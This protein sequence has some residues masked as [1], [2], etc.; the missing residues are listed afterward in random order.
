VQRTRRS[1]WRGRS[2]LSRQSSG[3]ERGTTA[4]SGTDC[5]PSPVVSRRLGRR[6]LGEG[7]RGTQLAT[8]DVC[9]RRLVKRRAKS[10]GGPRACRARLTGVERSFPRW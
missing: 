2:A 3:R 7:G 4:T 6:S 8:I 10:R 1:A 9:T 5:H